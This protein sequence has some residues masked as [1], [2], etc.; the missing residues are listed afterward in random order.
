MPAV[1]SLLPQ[2]H[3]QQ[4]SSCANQ[5]CT[6]PPWPNKV[7]SLMHDG[8]RM[9]F[10][11]P[12]TRQTEYNADE[13]REAGEPNNWLVSLLACWLIGSLACRLVGSLAHRLIGLLACRPNKAPSSMNAGRRMRIPPPS[14]GRTEFDADEAN[15]IRESN[16]R[17][18]GLSACQLAGSS[19]HRL[20]GSQRDKFGLLYFFRNGENP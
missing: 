10:P 11:P 20:V 1:L 7:P 19:A 12:S 5:E 4:P 2:Q 16:N 14:M 17:L 3:Q 13:A 9:R 8:R 6:H 15:K 18:I